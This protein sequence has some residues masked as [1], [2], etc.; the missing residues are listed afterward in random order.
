MK[1]DGQ[2]FTAPSI[3]VTTPEMTLGSDPLQAMRVLDDPSVSPL[4]ARLKEENGH[5]ILAD[6]KSG[7]GTWVNYVQ[8]TAPLVL[9]HGDILH[10][11]RF[12]FRFMLRKAPEIHPPHVLPVKK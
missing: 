2:P 11:G 4:H 1:E 3:P 7:T 5:F 12:A 9:Q 8:L 6:E 10:I